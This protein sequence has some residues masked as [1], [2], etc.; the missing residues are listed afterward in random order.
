M[1]RLS[2]QIESFLKAAAQKLPSY[3]QDTTSF[4]K[5]MKKLKFKGNVLI[6]ALDVESLYL[7]IDHY[8]DDKACE[9]QLKQRNETLDPKTFDITDLENETER[10]AM[11]TP[12]AGNYAKCFIGHFETNLLQ[13]YNKKLQRN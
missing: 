4:N 5:K 9:Y 7:N 13:G 8:E 6:A 3:V 10:T 2:E 12:M 1:K 11:G